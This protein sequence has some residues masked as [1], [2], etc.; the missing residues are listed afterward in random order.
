MSKKN[1][2]TQVEEALVRKGASKE[3]ITNWSTA[4]QSYAAKDKR[5]SDD[6]A[7]DRTKSAMLGLAVTMPQDSKKK[8]YV[9][10]V[11]GMDD[12]SFSTSVDTV[13]DIIIEQNL[14]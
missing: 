6:N 8:D 1:Y 5:C 3:S 4:A 2:T 10:T 14:L 9:S 13:V 12:G 7:L 11:Q